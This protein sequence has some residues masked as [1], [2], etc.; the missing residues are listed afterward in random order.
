MARIKIEIE[1][2][3]GKHCDTLDNVCPMCLEGDWGGW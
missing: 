1:V 2:P 3:S